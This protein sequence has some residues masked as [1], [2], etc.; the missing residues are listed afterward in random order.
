MKNFEI[1]HQSVFDKWSIEDN[2]VQ[3]IITSPPYW[4]LRKY[5]IPDI[6]I[7]GDKNCEHEFVEHFTPPKGGKSHPD[8]PSNVGAN[9][10]MSD[11]DIRG[12]GIKSSIHYYGQKKH[13]EF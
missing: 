1:K 9:R 12:V 2:S 5:A 10:V 11:M 4:G 13:T 6:I 7:G 8:R 3:S